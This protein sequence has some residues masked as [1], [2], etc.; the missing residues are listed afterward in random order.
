[1]PDSFISLPASRK[2]GTAMRM[3]LFI[4]V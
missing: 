2:N 3:K 1:M 4:P